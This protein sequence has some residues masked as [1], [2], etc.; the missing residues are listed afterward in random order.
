MDTTPAPVIW[1][2]A[3][4]NFTDHTYTSSTST[5]LSV[6]V[7]PASPP[8]SPGSPAAPFIAWVH[9]GGYIGGSHFIPFP[10]LMAGFQRRGY[11][12]VMLNYRLAPQASLDAQ[13]ADCVEQIAWCRA[14]LPSILGADKVDVDRYV[15]GG[16]SAGGTFST[17]MGLCLQPPP[18]AVV[19][20]YGVVDFIGLEQ[21]GMNEPARDEVGEEVDEWKGEFSEDTLRA[22][23]ADRDPANVLTDALSWNEMELIS[24]VEL[25]K[26]WVTDF[27]YNERIRLQAELHIWRSL[28][29]EPSGLLSCTM[30]SERFEGDELALRQFVSSMSPHRVLLERRASGAK[31]EYPPTAFLHGTGDVDVPISQSREMARVLRES[32]VDVVE[33]YEPEMPHVF[34]AKYTGPDVEGWDTYIQPILDFVNEHVGH[35]VREV[36][37]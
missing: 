35:E 23:L 22:Y 17:L 25:S 21:L 28:R 36:E 14:N 29:N 7:W 1:P 11:H 18:R 9:G 5:P 2:Q 33:S 24:D 19:D 3:P 6:R 27:R 26:R 31:V 8:P 12:L 13:L 16:E 30:H 37:A 20:V 34:D 32:G 15:V 4:P 10:W